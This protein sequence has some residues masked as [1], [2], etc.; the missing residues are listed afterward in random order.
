MLKSPILLESELTA[1]ANDKEL[2]SKTFKW[3][4]PPK[5]KQRPV[6]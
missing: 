6:S 3:V 5:W 2:K 1:I 4:G